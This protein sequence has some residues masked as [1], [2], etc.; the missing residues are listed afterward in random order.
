MSIINH[1]SDVSNVVA[2]ARYAVHVA[3]G[4]IQKLI[5]ESVAAQNYDDVALLASMARSL[6]PATGPASDA[7]APVVKAEHAPVAVTERSSSLETAALP[8]MSLAPKA[9]FPRFEREG[10]RLVKIGWS[11]KDKATY[12]HKTPVSAVMAV[13]DAIAAKNGKFEMDKVLPV[14]DAEGGDVPSYQAYIVLAWLRHEGIVER[15]GNDGYSA[16]R[17]MLN[18]DVITQKL[19]LLPN[20]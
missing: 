18:H 8:I 4:E 7:Q 10:N 9:G 19:N 6:M 1:A 17:A 14:K 16:N 11:K 2:R 15:N 13:G 12:E 3:H 5:T 20:R